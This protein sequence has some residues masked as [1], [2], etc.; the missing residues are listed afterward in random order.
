[1]KINWS[2]FDENTSTVEALID[3]VDRKISA[4]ILL[5]DCWPKECKT[6]VR[7]LRRLKVAN[8]R[9]RARRWLKTVN[10]L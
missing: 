8:S 9:R 10:R 5:A 4:D 1:M 6:E 7:K 3:F 2:V